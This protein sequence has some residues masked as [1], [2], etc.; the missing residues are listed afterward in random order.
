[1]AGAATLTA[2]PGTAMATTAMGIMAMAMVTTAMATVI[3]GMDSP[4]GMLEGCPIPAVTQPG[5]PGR[6]EELRVV[7]L[8]EPDNLADTVG[9]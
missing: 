1:M 9:L 8:A 5:M 2:V 4:A 7:N 3:T 6:A